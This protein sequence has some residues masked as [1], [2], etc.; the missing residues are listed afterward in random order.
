[1]RAATLPEADGRKQMGGRVASRERPQGAPPYLKALALAL[2]LALTL[3]LT[4]ALTLAALLAL[5][6]GPSP[7]P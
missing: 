7:W 5:A 3:T 6:L 1:M 2:A 4:L